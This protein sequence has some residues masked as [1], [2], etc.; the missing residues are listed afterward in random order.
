MTRSNFNTSRRL[1]RSGMSN[2]NSVAQ[3][4]ISGATRAP[5]A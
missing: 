2:L 1:I 4:A 5:G 3:S